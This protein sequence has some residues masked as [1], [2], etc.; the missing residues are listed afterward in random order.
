MTKAHAFIFVYSIT[1]KASFD[2]LIPIY[3]ELSL[4]KKEEL[5][6]VPIMIV[7]NKLDEDEQREVT[8]SFGE[9]LAQVWKCEFIETSAKSNIN[10]KELFQSLLRMETRRELALMGETKSRSTFAK[11]FRR[12]H[13]TTQSPTFSSSLGMV[14]SLNLNKPNSS[15]SCN[16][17]SLQNIDN[18]KE[19]NKKISNFQKLFKHKS[20]TTPPNFNNT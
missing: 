19:K 7:G 13:S 10:V 11:L 12:H 5:T 20:E 4:I 15:P 17:H 16:S 9:T 6:R 3:K 8:K 14:Q 1:N 18:K 2:E